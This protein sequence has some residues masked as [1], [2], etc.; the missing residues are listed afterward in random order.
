MKAS[1]IF[2]HENSFQTSK[3]DS[4]G[5]K[6]K[7]TVENVKIPGTTNQY[8]T[9]TDCVRENGDKSY[10]Y[11][12]ATTKKKSSCILRWATSK[13]TSQ[14]SPQGMFRCRL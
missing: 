6:F 9:V 10:Y 5:K 12:E 11:E 8:L 13:A 14:R 2:N 3:T 1:G 7:L 4:H